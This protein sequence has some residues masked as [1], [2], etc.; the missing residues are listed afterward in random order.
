[1]CNMRKKSLSDLRKSSK[2]TIFA[3]EIKLRPTIMKFFLLALFQLLP[4]ANKAQTIPAERLFFC[5]NQA[6]YGWSD[7]ISVDGIVMSTDTT[8][9][10]ASRYVNLDAFDQT[11]SLCL[12]VKL[13][14]QPDGSFHMRM[15]AHAIGRSGRC[16]LRAYTRL[17]LNYPAATL[18]QIAISINA[19]DEASP[20]GW[21]CSAELSKFDLQAP[22][23]GMPSGDY[24][25][26][27]QLA[28]TGTASYRVDGRPV[29]NGSVMAF[30]RSNQQVYTADT[31]SEGRFTI[32][33]DD[34]FT[35]EEFYLQAYDKKGKDYPCTF[36][37]DE[38]PIPPLPAATATTGMAESRA[39]AADFKQG[40]LFQVNVLPEVTVRS[41]RKYEDV[42]KENKKFYKSHY[43]SREDF[44]Q[45]HIM[46]L[47]DIVQYFSAFMYLW[48][49]EEGET[50]LR[51]RRESLLNSEGTPVKI[52]V[53]GVE[54]SYQELANLLNVDD[55]EEAEYKTPGESLGIPGVRFAIGGALVIKT[56]SGKP[57]KVIRDSYGQIFVMKGL[58]D[59]Q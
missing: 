15:P 50:L 3:C 21:N 2:K 18:P 11:D 20:G 17:M 51:S 24:T 40:G 6:E 46:T 27:T 30:Q 19:A 52:A 29:R 9:L 35:G 7:S 54:S 39:P 33:V 14:C 28:V 31:D 25:A 1:M 53:D 41:H 56:R 38:D 42:E 23:D 47:A 45:R 26:E 49:N 10:P 32:P 4:L 8:R 55:I 48:E 16:L 12:H 44:T 59:L 37:L 13:S 34:Y 57:G 58:D 43:L 22:I 5:S 36:T